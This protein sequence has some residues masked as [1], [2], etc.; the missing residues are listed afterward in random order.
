VDIDYEAFLGNWLILQH[1]AVPPPWAGAVPVGST[2]SIIRNEKGQ[3]WLLP[4]SGLLAP[5][6]IPL[7][8]EAREDMQQKKG[9]YGLGQPTLGALCN[10]FKDGAIE[11]LYLTINKS[12]SRRFIS[13][14]HMHPSRG[15]GSGQ[16]ASDGHDHASM[17][18]RSF[19]HGGSHGVDD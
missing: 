17:G 10:D 8:L 12:R 14:S 13:L 18:P 2:F 11:L 3:Y 1:D 6:D 5:F 16:H 7:M 9:E 19:N 15:T 4:G